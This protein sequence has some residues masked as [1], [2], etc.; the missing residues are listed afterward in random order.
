MYWLTRR[1]HPTWHFTWA[2]VGFCLGVASAASFRWL[3]SPGWLLVGLLLFG[4]AVWQQKSFLIVFA[5]LAGFITGQVRGNWGQ[6]ELS[7][8]QNLYGSN[9]TISGNLSEDAEIGRG[10]LKVLRLDRVHIGEQ[11]LPGK[12]WVTV[13][14]VSDL[15]REDKLVVSG[16]FT[17]GF[18]NFAGS[19]YRAKIVE[20]KRPSGNVILDLRDKF[21]S[22]LKSSI[23]EPE[24]SLGV[25]FLLGQKSALPSGFDQALRIAGLTHIV[26]A[27]GYNL[28][29]LVRLARKL[30]EK[31]SKYLVA[32]TSVGLIVGFI[33]ITGLSPSMTR[34][35]LVA[36]LSLAAWYFGRRFHPV[37]LLAFSAAVT[38]LFDPSFAWGN[39]GWELS[40]A[41][42]AGVM[43]FAPLFENYF[44]A[45]KKPNEF[46]RIFVETLSAQLLTL[47]IILAVFGQ[48]S[49]VA[50]VSN[51]LV[52]P[53]VPIAMLLSFFAGVSVMVFG[54][55]PL[56]AMPAQLL[57]GYMVKVIEV[58]SGFSWSQVEVGL[59]LIGV[60]M[61]YAVIVAACVYMKFATKFNLRTSSIIE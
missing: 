61:W 31:V 60:I 2:L 8:Y 4:I 42:F 7:A 10:G 1:V 20:A 43:I 28:T 5:L 27:S 9:V 3:V 47:P 58:T 54:I 38:L 24:S 33:N 19:I 17:E 52:L 46:R 22:S 40:F 26:V 49:V 55:V 21:S 12:V 30:F 41:A 36:T 18:G 39:I 59:P 45:D 37:T 48:F 13:S 6:Y 35:G 34:A 32:L 50:I 44:F 56:L 15:R 57:L 23:S 14:T 25:G 51:L 29:I 11:I 16:K 53:L